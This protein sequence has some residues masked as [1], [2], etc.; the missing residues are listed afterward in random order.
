MNIFYILNF[1]NTV[2]MN[3]LLIYLIL[4]PVIGGLLCILCNHLSI[5]VCYLISIFII[6][7][8]LFIDLYFLKL[9]FKNMKLEN[10]TPKWQAEYLHYWIPR[11]GINVHLALDGLSLLMVSLVIFFGILSILPS[12][13]NKIKN[14]GFFYSNILIL[15]SSII[16]IF[17]SV[18]MILLFIFWEITSISIY[19]GVLM[20]GNRD[21]KFNFNLHAANKFLMYSQIS[22]LLMLIVIS[23]LSIINYIYTGIFT[24]D[25]ETFVNLKKPEALEL[26]L[27]LGLFISFA[28]KLP[29][30]PFHSWLPDLQICTPYNGHLDLLGILIKTSIYGILRFVIPIFP[31]ASLKFSYI[32]TFFGLISIFYGSILAINQK[33]LKNF[34]SYSSISHMGFIIVSI[35][36]S[37]NIIFK[38]GSLFYTLAYSLSSAGI[39]L[40]CSHIYKNLKTMDIYK[41]GGLWQNMNFIPICA[42][43]FLL[44]IVGL[45]GTINFVAEVTIL[46]NIFK[47]HSSIAILLIL[48]LLFTLVYSLLIIQ[49]IY[50]GYK[51]YSFKYY[52]RLIEKITLSLILMFLFFIGIF[53]QYLI[54]II[55]TYWI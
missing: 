17:L 7:I 37:N 54:N 9:F 42:L 10:T 28:I 19:S 45:P 18:D 27:M 6:L 36:N 25:Y 21:L 38:Y 5:K 53:P 41:M 47:N 16:G 31:Q 49:R 55:T 29:I 48:S 11:F 46:F 34:I 15:I 39:I 20:Y 30:F 50:F 2:I 52:P 26:F 12:L 8:L 4:L 1:N 32:V 23:C 22:G 40:T 33:N 24:F 13:N 44:S 51:K 43:I 14:P 3:N 35:Y